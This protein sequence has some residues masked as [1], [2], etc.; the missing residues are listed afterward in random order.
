MRYTN[1]VTENHFNTVPRTTILSKRASGE[2]IFYFKEVDVSM[3]T[4][5]ISFWQV[6]K[7]ENRPRQ[8]VLNPIMHCMD[9][10]NRLV[11]SL[12]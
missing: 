9:L 3:K 10:K 11:L 6:W 2:C 4:H 1:S 5:S 7:N 8:I 12:K